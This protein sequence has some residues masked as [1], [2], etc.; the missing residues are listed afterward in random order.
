MK[1]V[2][3]EYEGVGLG[4]VS[5]VGLCQQIL[6]AQQNLLD[7]RGEK[8]MQGYDECMIPKKIDGEPL[9]WPTESVLPAPVKPG[10]QSLSS[11]RILKQT[12]P[13]GYTFGWNKGGVCA[14]G[15]VP[16]A[17]WKTPA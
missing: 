15:G 7:W 8:D 6:N 11:E 16:A 10:F 12:V 13:D 4:W 2:P 5:N 9:R 17:C 3:E 1:S 14:P